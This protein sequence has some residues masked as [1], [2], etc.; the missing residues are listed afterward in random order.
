MER[1]QLKV[2]EILLV[3]RTKGATRLAYDE[4]VVWL[5]HCPVLCFLTHDYTA[6]IISQ[7][8]LHGIVPYSK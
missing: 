5:A 8:A 2:A 7:S 1:T 6:Q 3:R 4:A